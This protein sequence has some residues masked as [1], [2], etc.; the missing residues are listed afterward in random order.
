MVKIA[1][2]NIIYL[3]G[4]VVIVLFILGLVGLR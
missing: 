1:M 2:N 4:V 3:V